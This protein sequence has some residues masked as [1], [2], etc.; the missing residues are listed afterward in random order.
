M[1]GEG[2][3]LAPELLDAQEESLVIRPKQNNDISLCA[4]VNAF[5]RVSVWTSEAYTWYKLH[6]R[7][8]QRKSVLR[9]GLWLLEGCLRCIVQFILA[10]VQIV[11]LPPCSFC[12]GLFY[13]PFPHIVGGD[14]VA[15]PS[16]PAGPGPSLPWDLPRQFIKKHLRATSRTTCPL[17]FLGYCGTW[18]W[19]S[20]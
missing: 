1:L 15:P 11:I 2:F 16:G 7:F 3:R 8:H 6:S 10:I 4:N 5:S 14:K 12:D 18:G 13:P 17:A 19:K 9:S 20:S